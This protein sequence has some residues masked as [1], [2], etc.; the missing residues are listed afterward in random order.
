MRVLTPSVYKRALIWVLIFV[1][2]LITVQIWDGD[3]AAP[4]DTQ[5][6]QEEGKKG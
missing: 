1:L 3:N 4:E 2:S 6:V 5:V